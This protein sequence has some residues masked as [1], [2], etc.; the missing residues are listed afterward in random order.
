MDEFIRLFA[1]AMTVANAAVWA[2][3]IRWERPGRN[4]DM[5]A[6]LRVPRVV[7]WCSGPLQV[8][9]FGFPALV[10]IAP[11]WTY[12]GPLNWLPVPV[13]TAVGAL[14]WAAGLGLLLW[15]ES[16]M[17][18][19][20]AVSG[21]TVGHELVTAGPYRRIRHPIYTAMIAIAVGTALVFAS[22]PLVAVAV[23]SIALHLWW[24]T[25][26]EQLLTSDSQLGEAYRTYASNTG[27]FLPRSP[28][29]P[30]SPRSPRD[31]A[32]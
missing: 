30:P 7:R 11:S 25:A 5:R 26:E 19:Y 15:A 8:I 10:A 22:W 18:G 9:P 20:A 27:R 16:G 4:L 32:E 17:R 3:A 21:A 1:A 14:A 12:T 2:I 6:T 29:S 28:R 13:V 23:L 24:A 31:G